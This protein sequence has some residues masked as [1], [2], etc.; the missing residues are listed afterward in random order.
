M[1]DEELN[2]RMMDLSWPL[3]LVACCGPKLAHRVPAQDLY[4]SDLFRKSRAYAE[5]FGYA[6]YILSVKHGIVPPN[7]VIDP[8]DETLARKSAHERSSWNKMVLN[9]WQGGTGHP[10][11]VLAGKDYRGWIARAHGTFS[12]PM[13][14]M[15]IGRQ[16]AWLK[17]RLAESCVCRFDEDNRTGSRLVD[18]VSMDAQGRL[19]R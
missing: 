9:Q 18:L 7:E 8:Y 14:G 12:V 3:V 4:T 17:A 13:E 11:V 16:K 15:G 5:Q 10:V 1:T 19:L 6:W 2:R